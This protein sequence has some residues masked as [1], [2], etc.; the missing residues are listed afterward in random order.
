LSLFIIVQATQ[1]AALESLKSVSNMKNHISDRD[2]AAGEGESS[3]SSFLYVLPVKKTRQDY[4]IRLGYFFNYLQV[5]GNTVE[6]KAAKF[7]ER[8]LSDHKWAHDCLIGYI[9]HLKNDT[10]RNLSGG[11]INNYYAPIKLFY[12]ANAINLNWKWI[13]KG[14][15]TAS[16]IANDRS[17][18]TDELRKLVEYPDRRIKVIVYVMASSGFRVDAWNYLKYKH[19]SSIFTS[20]PQSS[21]RSK[22]EGLRYTA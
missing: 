20:K 9:N 5:P 13:S 14:L 16:H 18:T 21:D 12:E 7:L 19:L 22:N 10:K 3:L 1:H 17:P 6:D 2:S 4:V 11:S 8:A 15:P